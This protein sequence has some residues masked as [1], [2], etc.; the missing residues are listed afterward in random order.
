MC[1]GAFFLLSE[2]NGETWAEFIFLEELVCVDRCL[3]VQKNNGKN[4]IPRLITVS[5][6]NYGLF[7]NG[8]TVSTSYRF[9][10]DPCA[11]LIKLHS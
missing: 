7:V 11:L 5:W 3:R 10:S 1:K 6:E 4:E 8:G 9:S 2:D